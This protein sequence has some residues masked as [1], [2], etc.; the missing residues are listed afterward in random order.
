MWAASGK[1]SRLLYSTKGATAA[2]VPQEEEKEAWI[3]QQERLQKKEE[4]AALE[5]A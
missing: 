4:L 1:A 2:A 3:A 5:T